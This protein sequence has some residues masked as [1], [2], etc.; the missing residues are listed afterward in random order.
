MKTSKFLIFPFIFLAACSSKVP[1]GS[2]LENEIEK[3]ISTCRH[4]SLKDFKKINGEEVPGENLYFVDSEF[5]IKFSPVSNADSLLKEIEGLREKSKEVQERVRS[6][7]R[8]LYGDLDQ[9]TFYD[10]KESEIIYRQ[11]PLGGLSE[12][13]KLEILDKREIA[14]KELRAKKEKEKNDLKMLNEESSDYAREANELEQQALAEYAK[15]CKFSPWA[16]KL[17]FDTK[18]YNHGLLKKVVWGEEY[19][20][21][22]RI[23]MRKTENGWIINK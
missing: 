19:S 3:E 2:E 14:L 13:E 11:Y 16:T 8:E 12:E 10:R 20:F 5:K 23:P 17:I 6:L 9:Y 1:T 22:Y 15:S 21:Q 18:Y 4:A 7:R